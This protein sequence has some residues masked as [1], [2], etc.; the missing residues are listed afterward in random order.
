MLFIPDCVSRNPKMFVRTSLGGSPHGKAGRLMELAGCQAA[1]TRDCL[2]P[3]RGGSK[4][5]Y[6]TF[7]WTCKQL[8]RMGLRGFLKR[9]VL[10]YDPA[11]RN[12]AVR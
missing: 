4:V 10:P 6:V 8:Q 1:L 11:D 5:F 3:L 7:V 9:L 2:L 12:G